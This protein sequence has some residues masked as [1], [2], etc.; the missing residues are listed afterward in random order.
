MKTKH[1]TLLI[2]LLLAM[3]VGGF[4]LFKKITGS[5]KEKNQEAREVDLEQFYNDE[6]EDYLSDIMEDEDEDEAEESAMDETPVESPQIKIAGGMQ[7]VTFAN[8][9]L[10]DLE[11]T[12]GLTLP[13]QTMA[14]N[15]SMASRIV[16]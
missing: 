7:Q 13:M 2:V 15:R 14:V 12:A 10:E 9:N 11:E 3:A 4:F 1:I 6:V 5:K 16:R 8:L